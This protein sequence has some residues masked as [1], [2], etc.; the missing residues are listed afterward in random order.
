MT[1]NE[2]LFEAGLLDEFDESRRA[3]DAGRMIALLNRV[4][5]ADQAKGIVDAILAEPGRYDPDRPRGYVERLTR[6]T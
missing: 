2:R 6:R 4:E 3:L 1:T 5:L